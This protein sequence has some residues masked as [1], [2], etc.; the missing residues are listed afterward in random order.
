MENC[1]ICGQEQDS[2]QYE[3]YNICTTCV[4][5]LEDVMTE[6]F[7]K[8]IYNNTPKAYDNFLN[9]LYRTTRYISDYKR[10]TNNSVDYTNKIDAR[11]K[12]ALEHT[13]NPSKQRY[14]EHMHVV[15]EWLKNNPEFYHYYF[16]EYYVCP[17]CSASLFEKYTTN[18]IGEWF[19]ITCSNCEALIKKFY[20]PKLV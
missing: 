11:A 13:T 12:D 18:S 1:T 9:Y 17:N 7:L 3:A 20:S 15:L 2:K 6:Y 5:I 16:K 10:L 4:D 19:V 8:T 14:F